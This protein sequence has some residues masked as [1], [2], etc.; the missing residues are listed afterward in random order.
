MDCKKELTRLDQ[1]AYRKFVNRGSTSF[2]CKTC[3]AKKLG[4]EE[5]LLDR[6]IEDFRRQGCSLFM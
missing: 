6:K 4:V 3:L 5:A 1:N 2:L